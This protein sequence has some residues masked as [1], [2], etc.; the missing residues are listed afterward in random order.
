MEAD[1]YFTERDQATILLNTFDLL[2]TFL[3]QIY[4]INFKVCNTFD[5]QE[6]DVFCGVQ[7][8][9]QVISLL[10]DK[11]IVNQSC[12]CYLVFWKSLHLRVLN[13]L[14]MDRLNVV[15][16][17]FL[18]EKV[19]ISEINEITYSLCKILDQN[20]HGLHILGLFGILH[21]LL[22]MFL[23]FGEVALRGK[24]S[25]MKQILGPHIFDVVW[26]NLLSLL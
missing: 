18:L 2:M 3:R 11:V 9:E 15:N 23:H 24:N 4:S 22:H 16:I 17:N 25:N 19:Y 13:H 21:H 14:V 1:P 26:L 12:H 5:R 6:L 20:T 10:W 8:L 7:K